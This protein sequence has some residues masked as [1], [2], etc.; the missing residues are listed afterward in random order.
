[1]LEYAPEEANSSSDPKIEEGLIN[2]K[3][4]N[5]KMV[6]K[7]PPNPN[8]AKPLYLK[9]HISGKP[10]RNIVVDNWS[11]VNVIPLKTLIALS[12]IEDDIIAT[13]LLVIAVTGK[14]A[15]ILGVIPSQITKLAPLHSL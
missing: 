15:K 4:E 11:T 5:G 1:M 10:L 3:L 13:D 9:T 7:K 8:H 2:T 12:K 6:F 14:A